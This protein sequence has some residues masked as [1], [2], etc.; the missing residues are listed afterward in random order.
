MRRRYFIRWQGQTLVYNL[1]R[2]ERITT[3]NA[4]ALAGYPNAVAWYV[5]TPT[6]FTTELR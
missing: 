6:T 4:L 2:H 3:M 5:D 1:T